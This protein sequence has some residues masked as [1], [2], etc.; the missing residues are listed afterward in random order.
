[1]HTTH[2][3]LQKKREGSKDIQ[4]I[5]QHSELTPEA[6]AVFYILKT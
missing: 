6:W 5:T 4:T 3:Q 1:M 2:Q